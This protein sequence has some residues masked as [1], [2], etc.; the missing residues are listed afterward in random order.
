MN[1]IGKDNPT[2]AYGMPDPDTDDQEKPL[3]VFESTVER[4]NL[5]ETRV[6]G[7]CDGCKRYREIIRA[8]TIILDLVDLS[9]GV[10][11]ERA[12]K[13]LHDLVDPLLDEVRR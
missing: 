1:T 3:P 11:R 5:P 12:L 2:I 10:S 7:M 6:E 4:Y 8:I 9:K 13:S